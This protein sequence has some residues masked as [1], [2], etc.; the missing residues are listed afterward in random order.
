MNL[1]LECGFT[2]KCAHDMIRTYTQ[3]AALLKEILRQVLPVNFAKFLRARK[4]SSK[5][6]LKKIKKPT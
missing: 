1:F 5:G 2:L 4:T 3:P 6:I